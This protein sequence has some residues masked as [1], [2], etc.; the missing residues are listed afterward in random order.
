MN[1]EKKQPLERI[2]EE[3]NVEFVGDKYRKTVK[4]INNWL[5]LVYIEEFMGDDTTARRFVKESG[6]EKILFGM[7]ALSVMMIG[8]S[9]LDS[10]QK[11]KKEEDLEKGLA[12][13]LPMLRALMCVDI[14]K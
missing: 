4:N 8:C 1:L 2:L 10:W 11:E 6:N 12:I 5:N 3:V 14:Y 9:Y 13:I 7:S